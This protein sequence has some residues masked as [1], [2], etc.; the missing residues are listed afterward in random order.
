MLP[1]VS[2]VVVLL[3][4]DAEGGVV[5]FFQKTMCWSILVSLKVLMGLLYKYHVRSCRSVIQH[6]LRKLLL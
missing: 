1:L 3:P 4:F 2:H 5:S 6:M